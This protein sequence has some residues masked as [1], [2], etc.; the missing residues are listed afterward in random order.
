[1][2]AVCRESDQLGKTKGKKIGR[3]ERML[4]VEKWEG[5]GTGSCNL[6]GFY[7]CLMLAGAR[8]RILRICRPA[9]AEGNA[10]VVM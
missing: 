9:Q 10:I 2:S 4:V 1:M 5:R 6:G 7:T 8:L 3:G